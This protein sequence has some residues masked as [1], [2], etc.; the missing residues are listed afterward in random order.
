M[1]TVKCYDKYGVEI[2]RLTQWDINVSLKIYDFP[3]DIAPVCH[4]A[5][6]FDKTAKTVTTTLDGTTVSVKVPN[7]LLNESKPIKIF[8]FLY[9]S[10]EDTGRTIYTIELP[11]SPKP[12]P[13][14]YEYSDNVEIIEITALKARLE[15]LVAEADKMVNVKIGELALAYDNTIAEIKTGIADDVHNLNQQI[16]N[17]NTHLIS[18]IRE[19]KTQLSDEIQ[20]A[21]QTLINGMK[22]GSPKGTF[23]IATD[24]EHSA[25][26][27]Y[28]LADEQNENNGWV[29]YWDGS[30]LSARI[31]YYAGMIINHDTITYS[32][33]TDEL[34]KQS[35]ETVISYVLPA[36]S[37][38]SGEQE[39][40]IS[41]EYTVTEHTKV[42][43]DLNN[44]AYNQ[45][46]DDGC[47][48]IYIVT[49]TEDK[50]T[51]LS[52]RYIGNAPSADITIQLTIRETV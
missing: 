51:S 29:Y 21:V 25:P 14:D 22:D 50:D 30:E 7:I 39:I 20:T 11:V 44:A 45:L 1:P 9:D 46:V 24:L 2:E 27:L 3:Y 31:L 16:T 43:V 34:K 38:D 37:W 42:D 52:A 23:K 12:R 8:V 47:V 15:A 6:R 48:G 35:V 28:L 13:D 26:G 49:Q 36:E 33:F 5:S 17:A 4:F 19:K 10:E 18:E 40:D 41:E 32:M